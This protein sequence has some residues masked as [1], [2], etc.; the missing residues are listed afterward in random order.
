VH[1]NQHT[2]QAPNANE[3]KDKEKAGE[4]PPIELQPPLPPQTIGFGKG[5]GANAGSVSLPV[6]VP[7]PG[8]MPIS[9]PVP[10]PSCG[11][12][13]NMLFPPTS[14]S[15]SGSSV[16]SHA[17]VPVSPA[18]RALRDRRGSLRLWRGRVV[19]LG[20]VV[21]VVVVRVEVWVWVWVL[22]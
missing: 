13:E 19:Q 5:S 3:D 9:I 7:I 18:R 15:A 17:P 14:T 21:W 20:L 10:T 6:P 11:G 16:S 2:P 12:T 4:L 8:P 22:G 1:P